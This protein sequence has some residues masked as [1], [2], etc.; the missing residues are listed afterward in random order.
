MRITREK[1]N[2]IYEFDKNHKPVAKV[3][4]PATVEFD[5]LDCFNGF[6]SDETKFLKDV[7]YDYCN[8]STGPVYFNDVKPGDV[9]EVK[10]RRIECESPGYTMSVENDG[11]LAEYNHKNITKMIHFDDKYWYFKDMKFRLS[12]MIGVIGVAP[13]EGTPVTAAPGDHGGNIDTTL[14]KEGSIVFLPVS[15]EGGLMAVGDVHAAM[16]D[17]ESFY[18][19]IEVKSHVVLDIK[20]RR[21]IKIDIPFVIADG[22][23]ASI[24]TAPDADEALKK[25]MKK[26]VDFVVDHSELDFYEAGIICGEMADLQISQMVD[27]E[28]TARMAINLDVLREMGVTVFGE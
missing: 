10:I 19:G 8:P 6:I 4:L 9:L 11:L 28:K 21:D 23:F 26:L 3:D 15:V 17:G 7:D 20:V 24:A 2:I 25:A 12:P 16:G 14:I 13:A 18:M 22:R 27:A 1:E 5:T